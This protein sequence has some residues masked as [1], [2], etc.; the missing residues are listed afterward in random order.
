[1]EERGEMDKRVRGKEGGREGGREGKREGRSKGRGGGERG[2]EKGCGDH[3]HLYQTHC[4]EYSTWPM[5]SIHPAL[6]REQWGMIFD[7][8]RR[9]EG[10]EGEEG[11][12][13]R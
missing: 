6:G 4:Y 10:R 9:E 8:E 2:G 13:G 7:R 5:N 12:G 1:M 3:C 11:R